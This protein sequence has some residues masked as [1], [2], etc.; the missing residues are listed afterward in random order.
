MSKAG[1]RPTRRTVQTVV[2][3]KADCEHRF[4][5]RGHNLSEITGKTLVQVFLFFSQQMK[6]TTSRYK[7]GEWIMQLWT[8]IKVQWEC[9]HT[10]VDLSGINLTPSVTLKLKTLDAQ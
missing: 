3:D 10:G 6:E 1:E 9:S 4:C 8:S 5:G 7:K 2:Y